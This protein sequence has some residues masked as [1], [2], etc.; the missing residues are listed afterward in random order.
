ML[1]SV[2]V[3]D[4]PPVPAEPAAARALFDSI[5]T[6][7]NDYIWPTDASTRITS[8]FAEYRS[9]HFHGGIDISTNGQTGYKAF[10]VRDGYVYKVTVAPNGYGKM[11]YLRHADGYV[12]TYAHLKTFNEEINS[13]V[14]REQ[15]RTGT[16]GVD[17]TF[18][19][20]RIPVKKG[21]VVAYTGDTG[22]GPPH[23]HFEIRDENLNPVN[24][25]LCTSYA[26]R[27]GLSPMIRRMVVEPLDASSTVEQGTQPKFFSRF[28]GGSRSLRLPQTLR[29]H[30]RIGFGVEAQDRADG[31]WTRSGIHRM[32]L[33]VDDRLTYAMQLDRIPAADSKMIL[34]HYDLPMIRDGKGKFQ[35]LFIE[36]GD[37]LPIYEKRPEGA[38]VISTEDLAEG[39]HSFRIVCKDISGNEASL[40]GSFVANHRPQVRIASADRDE[41]V[42]AGHSMELVERCTVYGKSNFSPVWSQHTLERGRFEQDGEG[43]EL[44]VDT[45][46]YDVV[47][48]VVE[49]K[50]GSRS[51]P[52]IRFLKKPDGPAHKVYI[53]H[54]VVG[55]DLRV[56]V[57]S[58]GVFTEMPTVTFTEGGT[59]RPVT[60][61]AVDLS[62]YA[63]VVSLSDGAS[64]ARRIDV[65]S[66]VNKKSVLADD[67]FELFAVAPRRAGSFETGRG[68][69]RVRY[70]SGA[71]FSPLFL[72][73][74][75]EPGRNGVVYSLEPEDV[76]LKKGITVSVPV[77]PGVRGDH[78]GLYYRSN[79]GWVFQ[80]S[81]PDPGG[82]SYSA[83]LTRTLGELALFDDDVRPSIGRLKVLPRS[84]RL[85]VGFRYYDNL[86]GVDANEIKLYIDDQPAIPEIDGERRRVWFDSEQPLSRGKHRLRVTIRDRAGNSSEELRTFS[87]R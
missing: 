11:L 87:I 72:R 56:T 77:P 4:K 55:S 67:E 6:N 39:P 21:D 23:L 31:T 85:Y 79:A 10:A 48:V 24:P 86:S 74:S 52:M 29:L 59:A 81:E 82:A 49:T 17:M 51:A 45:R 30:G 53:D 69:L 33:Y 15:Y 14:R 19:P 5:K 46:K 64:G 65:A 68:G 26:A 84:G 50:S 20:G 61:E 42:L 58:A 60:M 76:L 75:D 40:S 27:D 57:T 37:D 78:L 22:F 18:E 80:T 47:K 1:V 41:I 8:S 44:P 70:D 83:Q 34:L 9:T 73:A 71:V 62:K 25:M 7:L 3:A 66:E 35:K 2:A 63:G 36:E 28:P 43:I 38:G 16:Y 54:E 13:A 32:E 12:S